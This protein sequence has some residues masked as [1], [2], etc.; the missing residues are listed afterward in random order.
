[1]KREG[2]PFQFMYY[3]S[4]RVSTLEVMVIGTWYSNLVQYNRNGQH[5]KNPLPFSWRVLLTYPN[6]LHYFQKEVGFPLKFICLVWK[7]Y[8]GQKLC[9]FEQVYQIIEKMVNFQQA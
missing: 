2:N 1:M 6:F 9:H 4:D 3:H 7:T 8:L 5:F